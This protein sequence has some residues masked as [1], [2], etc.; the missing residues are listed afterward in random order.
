MG[1]DATVGKL[2]QDFTVD[3]T[4]SELRFAV[5]GGDAR[6]VLMRGNEIVRATRARRTNDT[7]TP[8]VWTLSRFRGQTLRLMIEDSLTS[9]WGFITTTGFELR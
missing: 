7:A 1:T 3:S 8:V 2:W 9:A 4:T 6:V 5:H